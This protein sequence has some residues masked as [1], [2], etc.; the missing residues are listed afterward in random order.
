MAQF[1]PIWQE[2]AVVPGT[3]VRFGRRC[4]RHPAWSLQAAKHTVGVKDRE[5]AR[6]LRAVDESGNR[7]C[8]SCTDPSCGRIESRVRANQIA[9]IEIKG[10]SPRAEHFM[11]IQGDHI[12][13]YICVAWPKWLPKVSRRS[14]TAL[15][16]AV[17]RRSP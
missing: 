10:Q 9:V 6:M 13:T 11:A 7:R 14:S 5:L 17:P 3:T 8:D 2:N 1:N 4:P 12:A 16:L 15:P